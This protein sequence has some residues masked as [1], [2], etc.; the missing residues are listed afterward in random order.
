MDHVQFHWQKQVLN[1]QL[2]MNSQYHLEVIYLQNEQFHLQEVQISKQQI[3][4][5]EA[6]NIMFNI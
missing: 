2:H 6:C 4:V 5:G 1:N 3:E